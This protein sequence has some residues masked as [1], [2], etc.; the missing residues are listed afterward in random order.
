[1][2]WKLWQT[3]GRVYTLMAPGARLTAPKS[4]VA[5]LAALRK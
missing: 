5:K 3:Q 4:A 2:W 1:M